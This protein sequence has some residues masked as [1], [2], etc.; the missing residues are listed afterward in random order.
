MYSFYSFLFLFLF[1][2][3]IVGIYAGVGT[4][5][6]IIED[7][8][9]VFCILS[10]DSFK[11]N[12]TGSAVELRN[13]YIRFSSSFLTFFIFTF[14]LMQFRIV[15]LY[16]LYA[17]CIIVFVYFIPSGIGRRGGGYQSTFFSLV[18]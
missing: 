16:P 8:V 9:L 4:G 11:H 10:F 13:P 7:G 6:H 15:L 3:C 18:F 17:F 2:A 14:I 1:I 12:T 5:H